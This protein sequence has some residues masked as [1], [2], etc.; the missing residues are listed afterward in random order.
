MRIVLNIAVALLL[1][2]TSC[3]KQEDIIF[4]QHE[5]MVKYLTTTLKLVAEEELGNVLDENPPFYSTIDRYV[6]RHVVNYYDAGRKAQKEVVW[7]STVEFHFDAYL[8]ENGRPTDIYWSNTEAT[9]E[10]F[11]RE[12]TNFTVDWSTEPLRVT[13]GAT[14]MIEGLNI[15]LPGCREKDSVQLFITSNLAYGKKIVG[16]VPKNTAVA[17]YL[18]IDKV[19]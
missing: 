11:R 17:W 8:V 9:F 16:E 3:S 10:R 12:N 2:C 13:L 18:K 7:G 15:A 4:A 14:E 6:Y 19:E 1:L 5:Q